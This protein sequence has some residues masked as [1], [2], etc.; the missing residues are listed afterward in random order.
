MADSGQHP[1]DGAV[2]GHAAYEDF[3]FRALGESA[4]LAPTDPL[5]PLATED[6]RKSQLEFIY[7]KYVPHT[8]TNHTHTSKSWNLFP[9]LMDRL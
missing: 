2:E 7:C 6:H 9:V 3:S 5:T 1:Q 8:H 4:P